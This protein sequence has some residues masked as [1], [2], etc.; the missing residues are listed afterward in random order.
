MYHVAEVTGFEKLECFFSFMS[1]QLHLVDPMFDLI[2]DISKC[3]F[4]SFARFMEPASLNVV[5]QALREV[6]LLL[7]VAAISL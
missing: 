7:S 2:V 5:F 4:P 1:L 3:S 6:F